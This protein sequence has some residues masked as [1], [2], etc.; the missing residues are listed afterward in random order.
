MLATL[1][2]RIPAEHVDALLRQ[3]AVYPWGSDFATAWQRL[4]KKVRKGGR[5]VSPP[6]RQLLTGLTAVHGQPVRILDDWQL[7]DDDRD[8]G[9]KGMI[10]TTEAIDPFHLTTC[11]RTFEQ[12]LRN[13]EDRNTL[14]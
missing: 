6:Y 2:F 7:S 8:A 13:G 5:P 3:V 12:Q 4:P 9:I 1:G 11:L 10:V 14:A